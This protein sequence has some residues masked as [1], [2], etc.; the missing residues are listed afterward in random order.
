MIKDIYSLH[1]RNKM[2]VCG[3]TF[4]C[5]CTCTYTYTCVCMCLEMQNRCRCWVFFSIVLYLIAWVR[6]SPWTLSLLIQKIR[7]ESSKD[8][9]LFHFSKPRLQ[10]YLTVS[11]T[12]CKPWGFKFRSFWAPWAISMSDKVEFFLSWYMFLLLL[13]N[14]R[15]YSNALA[16]HIGYSSVYHSSRSWFRYNNLIKR[17]H[18]DVANNKHFLALEWACDY[19]WLWY[20]IFRRILG[21]LL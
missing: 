20:R 4:S 9:P 11:K 1:F 19:R 12:L 8:T 6:V 5:V 3:C 16:R 18:N 13:F 21:D 10:A 14:W 15:V 2:F 17:F 7:S